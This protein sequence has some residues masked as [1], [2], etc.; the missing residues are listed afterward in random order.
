MCPVSGILQP[1]AVSLVENEPCSKPQHILPLT[2]SPRSSSGR[3]TVCIAPLHSDLSLHH[4]LINSI[5][6]NRILGA[7]YFVFYNYS[8]DYVTDK[9]LS[10][11][12]R[13]G[14][15]EVL[16]WNL[17][18]N[19]SVLHYYGQNAAIN[20]CMFRHRNVTDYVVVV[21][22]DEFIL[23]KY[24]SDMTWNDIL[25][26]L[27][28]ASSYTFRHMPFR[29]DWNSSISAKITDIK[30]RNTIEKLK[31]VVFSKLDRESDHSQ[32]KTYRAKTMVN[33]KVTNMTG[34]HTVWEHTEGSNWLVDKRVAVVNHYRNRTGLNI[35][36]NS[37]TE[38]TAMK[39]K[40]VLIDRVQK[41]WQDIHNDS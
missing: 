6:F 32:S 34:I 18:L 27:P 40:N 24:K 38:L 36:V 20:D 26:R 12:S 8:L 35:R 14:L 41:I 19:N 25:K 21:D 15:A 10:Y 29:V 4:E 13:R 11:Y 22:L 28:K 1:F 39:Y 5:E 17:K 30:E 16:S 7:D 37:R 3:F 33:P 2:S 31:L 23:P 9:I